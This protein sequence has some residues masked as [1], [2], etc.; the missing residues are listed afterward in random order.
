[1]K[2]KMYVAL[3]VLASATLFAACNNTS[4]RN[5]NANNG[6]EQTAEPTIQECFAQFGMDYDKVKPDAGCVVHENGKVDESN[7]IY[8]EAICT[9]TCDDYLSADV[10]DGYNQRMFDYCKTVAVDGKLLQIPEFAEDASNLREVTSPADA[11]KANAFVTGWYMK[12]PDYW[13]TVYM[14][15]SGKSKSIGMKVG[16]NSF[17]KE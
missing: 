12:T 4:N 13:V 7:P 10:V 3:V 9:E 5:E 11:L 17:K 16:C 2:I 6:N 8:S 14:Q 1:M 15:S